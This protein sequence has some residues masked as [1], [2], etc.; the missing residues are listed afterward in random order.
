MRKDTILAHGQ[1]VGFKATPGSLLKKVSK[2]ERGLKSPAIRNVFAVSRCPSSS[3]SAQNKVSDR[4][5]E[6]L[7]GS[8]V[9]GPEV[10]RSWVTQLLRFQSR[11]LTK[12]PRAASIFSGDGAFRESQKG[13]LAVSL[14]FHRRISSS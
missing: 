9:L 12:R 7:I 11:M 10:V 8:K 13:S 6:L 2:V 14:T 4:S 5:K 1:Q 3:P